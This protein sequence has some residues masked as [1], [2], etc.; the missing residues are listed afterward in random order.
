MTF[1][2]SLKGIDIYL[3]GKERL[4]NGLEN[5]IKKWPNEKITS[6]SAAL[7]KSLKTDIEFLQALKRQLTLN[8]LKPTKSACKHPKK[9]R[10]RDPNR[11]WYC[12]NCNNDL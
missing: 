6:L 11:T 12:M 3:N 5:E 7:I 4:V 8:H 2:K 9:M 1:K 10:D